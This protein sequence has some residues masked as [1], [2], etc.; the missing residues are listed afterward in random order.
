MIE[1][2]QKVRDR[3]TGFA[4]I[5]VSRVEHLY[6]C[7]RIAIEPTELHDGKPILSEWFDE[8]RVEAIDGTNFLAEAP[9]TNR[10]GGP[11][12]NPPRRADP[13]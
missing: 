11:A 12:Q 3:L 1:L 10:P 5:A 4:G 6:G 13:R 9:P 8:Q 7:S 2:G